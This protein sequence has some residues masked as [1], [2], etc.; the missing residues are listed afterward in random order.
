MSDQNHIVNT[1][2]DIDS[3]Q[4]DIITRLEKI[5]IRLDTLEST[6][7]QLY[8]RLPRTEEKI[9]NAVADGMAQTL[10]PAVDMV[11]RLKQV[12]NGL[13]KPQKHRLFPWRR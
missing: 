6:V 1:L 4:V 7:K 10:Q 2:T 9:K 11:D 13:T 8:D 5:S 12:A 3:G